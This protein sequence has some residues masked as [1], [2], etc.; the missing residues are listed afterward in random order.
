MVILCNEPLVKVPTVQLGAFQVPTVG[1]AETKD[2]PVGSKSVTI[3]LV[4]GSTP[5]FCIVMVNV[6]VLPSFTEALFVVLINWIS[7]LQ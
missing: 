4:A 6:I 2:K 1:V 5:K 3:K 7:G